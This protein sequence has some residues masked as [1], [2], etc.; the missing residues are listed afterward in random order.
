MTHHAQALGDMNG[1]GAVNMADAEIF[2]AVLLGRATSAEHLAMADMNQD[3]SIDGRDI[4]AFVDAL[5][6]P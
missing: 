1:D 6:A 2:R 3:G 4:Q 5:L